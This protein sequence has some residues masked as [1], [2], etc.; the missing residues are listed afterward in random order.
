MSYP[1]RNWNQ[2]KLQ[3]Q[4]KIAS[5]SLKL[6][7]TDLL[8]TEWIKRKLCFNMKV[9]KGACVGLTLDVLGLTD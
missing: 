1:P 4:D 8:R 2:L 6:K 7:R 3:A 9:L 5:R